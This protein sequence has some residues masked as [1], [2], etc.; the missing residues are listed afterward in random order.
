MFV[1]SSHAIALFPGGFGTLD[2]GFEVLTL[3]QT[4]KCVPMPIVMVEP[5]GG[6]YW[7]GWQ[8]YVENEVLPRKLI[9][10]EDLRLYKVTNDVD[11]A[12]A[13]VSK[14]YSN[15]HSLRYWRDEVIIRVH[16]KPTEAQLRDLQSQF[17]E[18]MVRGDFRVSGPLPIEKD[19]PSLDRLHRLVFH[20]NRREFGK[21]R[22]LIDHLNNMV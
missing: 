2:E 5:P 14:F 17:G 19:E 3:I 16:H 4:G 1:R 7:K 20:F 13:E 11:A 18:I 6:N 12:I 21:L 22:I 8:D 10:P 15:Y 9:N